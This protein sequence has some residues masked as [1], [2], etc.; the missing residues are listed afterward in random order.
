MPRSL[1]ATAAVATGVALV[2]AAALALAGA[3]DENGSPPPPGAE[4]Q[5]GGDTGRIVDRVREGLVL[6]TSRRGRRGASGSG[7]MI[8][9]EGL[10]LTSR[11]TVARG[12]RI[13][14]RAEGASGPIRAELLGADPATDIALL[15]IPRDDARALRPLGLAS[16][17][18]RVRIGERVVA[19]G[20]PFGLGGTVTAG[21]VSAFD[22]ELMTPQGLRIEGAIQTDAATGSGNVGGPLV[23]G[24]GNVIGMNVQAREPAGFAV[25]IETAREVADTIKS[26]GS[27]E[28]PYIGMA[29]VPLTPGLAELLGL[30]V[31]HGL[32]IR[33]VAPGGPADRAGVHG[34][35][36]GQPAGDVVLAIDGQA[37]REPRDATRMVLDRKPGDRVELQLV[38]GRRKLRLRLTL[39]RSPG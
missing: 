14:V 38:R 12:R 16:D 3:I 5:G 9:S 28:A 25:P 27:L 20:T 23:D 22:Q 29:G 17:E 8:D 19:V 6:V 13:A 24:G 7:F 37:V 10:I 26:T 15:K 1:L 39:G 36:P 18:E 4:A 30:G 32:L 2:V 11:Q 33:S 31:E 35:R 34:A 21:V